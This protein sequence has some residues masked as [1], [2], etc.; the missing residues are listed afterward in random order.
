MNPNSYLSR[1]PFAFMARADVPAGLRYA[2]L[3]SKLDWEFATPAA[4]VGTAGSAE[5]SK[6]LTDAI[7]GA[8]GFIDLSGQW[9]VP[10]YVDVGAG[11]SRLTCRAWGGIGYGFGWGDAILGYPP[12]VIRLPYEFDRCGLPVQRPGDRRGVQVLESECSRGSLTM[13]KSTIDSM[14]K[15][16]GFPAVEDWHC[17]DARQNDA[18]GSRRERSL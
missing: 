12:S 13:V 1:L 6:S 16:C 4:P 8:R 2:H 3:K 5:V 7:L 15:N 10:W 9:F 18:R 11:S 14:E 17:K